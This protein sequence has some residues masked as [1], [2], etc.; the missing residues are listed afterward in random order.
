[1]ESGH[2]NNPWDL[3]REFCC[4]IDDSVIVIHKL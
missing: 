4:I 3:L 1:M 2:C